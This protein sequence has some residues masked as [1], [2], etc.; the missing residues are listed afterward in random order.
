M[1]LST[2][3]CALTI[4]L[5]PFSNLNADVGNIDQKVR[6]NAATWFN[7]LDQNVITAYPAKGTLDAELDRQVVLTYKQNASS[8][9]LALANNDKIQN[10][11][12]VRNEFRQS[13]LSGLGESKISYYDF[14]GLT[15]RLEGVVNTASRAADTNQHNRLRSYDFILKDR[16]LRG[17]PYQ[18]MD[19]NTG[20]YLP[21]Y[22]EATT[23][24]RGRKFSS[25]PSGHTSN[26]FGQAVSLALAFPERGQ[27]LFSRALQYGESRVVLGA[28]FPT[29]TIASRMARYYYMAQLLNDDEIATALS[30]M[31]RTTRFPFEEL[32]GKS[33]SH[34]LSDLPTPVFD[35]HQKDHFQIGYYG[36]LRTETPVSITPEQLPS[37]SPALLRLRFPYLNEA[38]RKQILASTAYP[39]NS[40]AQRGDLTKPDNNWGLI[41]LPLAYMGPRY[42]F[43]DLQTSAIPEHKLDIAHYS[44]QD[45]WSQNITGSGK[46]IINHAGKLHLSGNNQFAGVEVNAG[47]LTLSGHNHFSGDS[48]LNQQA[49]LNLSGQLHSPIKLHQQAKL[50]IRPSNKGMNIYAQAIDL[51]DRT[52]TL[53]IS[54]AAHNI[55]ELSGKGSVNLTVEDNYSPLNV[56]TLSGELTFNQQV[57]LSKKIATIINT[58]TANGRHRLYLDIKE[59]GTVPEKFALTLVDTQK[60]GATFSLVDEQGI[61]LSQIDVGDIGYQLKKAGQRWQLSNQLNSLE[62]HASGIIQAL[63]ANA[64]T[65]QLLFHHTTP[66][67][68]EAGKGAIVWADTNIQQ[69]H[70]HSGNIHFSLNAKH[71]TL[72]SSKTWQHHSGW[73]TLSLQAEMNKANLTHPLGGRSQV[74]GYGVGIYA[75]YHAHSNVAIEGAMNYSYFQHHLHIKNTRGES[76]G[77][78]SQP[79]WGTMLKLSYTHK[80]GNLNIR[81]ALSTH[82]M[83]S[84]NKSFALS[85]HIKTK[86]QSQA[87]LYSGIGVNMEYVLTAGNIEIRPHLEVEKRYSLSKH[88]TNIISRNGLSWQGVSVAK[89]QGLTAG[90]NTK[91]G[92]VLALDTTFE[93]A[94]QENTQQK[95][96]IKLQIQYEF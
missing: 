89:Q 5:Y 12:H 96:A 1:K 62:Y 70:L 71:I 27:E 16:Y 60:N 26:G 72:G 81:P 84:H 14:A 69:Y 19:S 85:D 20:E 90:I 46:L 50:N 21:N 28:H 22:D 52:T 11:D 13:A 55:T 53:N 64:T 65:P 82:Y 86:I 92:K 18:V 35:T 7:Q 91:I 8:Q 43:E 83:N 59:S 79:I 23:D 94:K 45:T 93:Y 49:V 10:V 15:S 66:K 63:L 67:L 32:C 58:Q 73:G 54:T 80:L 77:Q 37:T 88:P 17:R 9:R 6:A 3:S 57:D 33:L 40:L 87:V 47:E 61:A 31:A 39:A 76:V 36:Q 2:L 44:K 95:K 78:F 25:Y 30:Q 4:V 29:D 38:A 48:Q 75:K 74:K 41:N 56:D 34:C 51:A 68:T 24:S 42:L